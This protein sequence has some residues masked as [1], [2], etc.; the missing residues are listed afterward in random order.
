MDL[1]VTQEN[2]NKALGN[3]ARVASGR[4]T[5]PILSNVLVQTEGNRLKVSATNLDIAI[6]QNVGTKIKTEG[7][8]TVPA[9]LFQDFI[10]NLPKTTITLVQEDHK[11]HVSA[12]SYKSTINGTVTDEYPVMPAI[13]DGSTFTVAG[14]LLKKALQQVI[15]AASTDEARPILTAV[16]VYTNEGKL[17]IAATDSYRLAEKEVAG[18]D[19]EVS[20]LIPGSAMHDLLRIIGDGEDEVTVL[21]DDQQVR[22]SVGDIEL[23]ARLIEGTY[24]DYRKLIPNDFAHKATVSK[25]ELITITKISGLFSRENA[26]SI[27][28]L[29]SEET[30]KLSVKSIA[31]QVGENEASAEGEIQGDGEITLNSRYLLE[32]LQALEGDRVTV[33]FNGKLDAVILASPDKKNYMHVIMPLKS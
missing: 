10:S 31:S 27:T 25:Q 14:S 16:Y 23:I 11:L 28:I 22:F 30:K 17:Y 6:S 5:L 24:P 3:V 4:N 26:G 33:S 20:L 29:T 21:H 19:K 1:Q 8:L 12:D 9:R 15:F 7:S 2:L 18:I 32:G 13:Q